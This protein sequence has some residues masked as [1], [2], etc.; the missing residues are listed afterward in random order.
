M[1][2]AGVSYSKVRA[3]TRV[4]DEDNEQALLEMARRSAAAQLEKICRLYRGTQRIEN[5]AVESERFVRSRGTDDQ[6]VSIQLKLLPEEA[7]RFLKAIEVC[8]DGGGLADGAVHMAEAALLGQRG[9]N[10]RPP[11]EVV[12]HVSAESLEGHT[13][14]GDGIPAGTSRRL[15]CDCGVVPML[16]DERGKTLDVGRK[17]RTIPAALRRALEARDQ[18]CQFPGCGHLRY[19]DAHHIE[20]WID[21]GATRLSNLSSV[22]RRHHRYLHEYG[23]SIETN[24]ERVAFFDPGGV[25]IPRVGARGL[26]CGT[27]D[28]LV[29]RAAPTEPGWD[30]F[31]INYP[32]CIE[33]L[34]TP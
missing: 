6:M 4:A 13:D 7:A 3:M 23:F 2:V 10:V 1:A 32:L 33:A 30:G 27:L 22:C 14:A 15:L 16:E 5:P 17:R 26:A 18:G 21:G 31:P 24:G 12:V 8:T 28:A 25:E 20:H 34:A 29:P 9:E 11:V 19:L